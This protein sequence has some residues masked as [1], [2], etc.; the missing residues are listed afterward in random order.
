[1]DRETREMFN[2]VLEEMSRMEERMEKR[3]DERFDAVDRRF[4]RL[5]NRMEL[6]HHE[7]N[8]CKLEQESVGM[9]IKHIDKLEE[10][11]DEHDIRITKLEQ[12]RQ[13]NLSMA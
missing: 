3:M 7:V 1:M 13:K 2:A 8:A 10:K 12:N 11:V 5:E 4:E 9:L 6:L